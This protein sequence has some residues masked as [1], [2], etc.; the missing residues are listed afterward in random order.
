MARLKEV[1]VTFSLD[2][3]GTGYASLSVLKTL[4]FDQVKID[5]SFVKEL[6]LNRADAAIARTVITLGDSLD[7]NVIAEGVETEAHRN[8]LAAM[9]CNFF[10]GYFFAKPMPVDDFEEWIRAKDAPAQRAPAGA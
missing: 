5:Q 1:G 7:I 9:N 3:F 4:P 10:Q 2:D 6:L 8:T